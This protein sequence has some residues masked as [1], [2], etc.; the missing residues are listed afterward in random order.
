MDIVGAGLISAAGPACGADQGRPVGRHH[1]REGERPAG[2]GA[3]GQPLRQGAVDVGD[4]PV[5]GHG[6]QALGQV[7]IEREHRPEPAHGLELARALAGHVAHLPQRQRAVVGASGGRR[8]SDQATSRHVERILS[9]PLVDTSAIRERGFRVALDA[10]AG[11]G[12]LPAMP[13]LAALG[14][15]VEGLHLDPTGRFPR[16]PEPTAANLS[17]LRAHVVATGADL[18]L[19]IDPDG[20]VMRHGGGTL[21]G[22]YAV[23]ATTGGLEGGTEV[24]Y[25]GGLIKAVTFGMRAAERIA[26]SATS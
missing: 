21:G 8:S 5:G 7:V 6:E 24:G 25:V 14:V 17:E 23:G 1:I 13:L 20:Q 16:D 12:G 19:A 9:D 22:L 4:A 15:E 3:Q 2:F 10:C 26:R 18:G 11:A